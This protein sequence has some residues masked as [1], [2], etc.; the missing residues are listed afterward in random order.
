MLRRNGR[1]DHL[2]I[3]SLRLS[4]Y[5]L[6]CKEQQSASTGLLNGCFLLLGTGADASERVGKRLALKL[7]KPIAVSWNVDG[8]D[9]LHF[10]AEKQLLEHLNADALTAQTKDLAI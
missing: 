4:I 2:V 1:E 10:W 5:K 9:A 3:L 7:K 6:Q 8:D